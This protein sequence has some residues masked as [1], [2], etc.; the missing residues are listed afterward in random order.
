MGQSPEPV[1]EQ[2]G[3]SLMV[4][5]AEGPAA[6]GEG[7]AAAGVAALAARQELTV[8]R[9]VRARELVAGTSPQE[10]AAKIHAECGPAF[11]TTPVRSYRLALG[12]ALG[13]VVA[14]VKAWYQADGR[15]LPRFSETL[16]SAY[17]SGQKRP[18]PEYLH[19]L[20]AVYR[21]DPQDLGYPVQCLCGTGHRG[22]GPGETPTRAAPDKASGAAP[23]RMERRQGRGAGPGGD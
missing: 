20:C 17:E 13:D 11:G 9:Q 15:R 10:I 4:A 16:L 3:G 6:V 23:L 18:G 22:A 5:S 8:A 14:Q 12:I 1:P 19:Y 21:A 7:P 2:R